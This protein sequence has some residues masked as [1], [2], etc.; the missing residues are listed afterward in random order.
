MS[1]F[2]ELKESFKRQLLR[3]VQE[4]LFGHFE[5]TISAYQRQIDHKRRL[6]DLVSDPDKLRTSVFPA[7]VLSVDKEQLDRSSVLDQEAA[8]GDNDGSGF[9]QAVGGPTDPEHRPPVSA[10]LSSHMST[11]SKACEQRRHTPSASSQQQSRRFTC[12]VCGL[13]LRLRRQLKLHMKRHMGEKPHSCSLCNQTFP[14][15]EQLN[16]H[17]CPGSSEKQET[18]RAS[19]RSL[20]GDAFRVRSSLRSHRTRQCIKKRLSCSEPGRQQLLKSQLKQQRKRHRDRL[21]KSL[22]RF[23]DRRRVPLTCPTC[24]DVF[25]N[26]SSLTLHKKLH[27][28]ELACAACGVQ[29]HS[30]SQL[31]AHMMKCGEKP[32]RCPTCGRR[33]SRRGHLKRH[34]AVHTKVRPHSCGQCGQRFFRRGSLRT[35][36]CPCRSLHSRAGS[37]PVR[38]PG[39]GR[40]TAHGAYAENDVTAERQQSPEQVS[41]LDLKSSVGSGLSCSFCGKGFSCAGSLT[42]HVSVHTGQT[43]LSCIICAKKFAS[44][45]ELIGHDCASESTEPPQNHGAGSLSCSVCSIVFSDTDALV[46]HMRSH[47]RLTRFTCPVCAKDFAWRRHLTK[48]M[49]VHQTHRGRRAPSH[50]QHVGGPSAADG[51]GVSAASRCLHQLDFSDC[52]TDDSDFWTNPSPEANSVDADDVS[53]KQAEDKEQ[54]EQTELKQEQTELT[55]EQTELT[56][57]QTELKQE[58]P[59][60]KEEQEEAQISTSSFGLVHMKTEEEEKPVSSELPHRDSALCAETEDSEDRDPLSGSNLVTESLQQE[61]DGSVDSDFWKDDRDGKHRSS[62][63]RHGAQ[64]RGVDA[65]ARPRPEHKPLVC[66]VCGQTCLYESHLKIHMRTHTGEKPFSCPICGKKYAHKASMQAHVSVHTIDHRYHCSA[67]G[68]SFAWFTELK[69][70]QCAGQPPPSGAT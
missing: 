3:S 39:P 41:S 40:S 60:V 33:F 16:G 57:E 22:K 26:R 36:K 27:Q 17:S 45:S 30:N 21:F 62:S 53:R 2:R 9:S 65:E 44:E 13:Q 34:M 19:R 6:L 28:N 11:H 42:R 20:R 4:R 29:L 8:G 50:R 66:A 63:K 56:Q 38:Y 31:D 47:A 70:H 14:G 18:Q 54:Q 43:L 67:C 64:H 1:R 59:W 5:E 7:D 35:H 10:G 48:H 58:Q 52:D 23:Q 68:R 25:T 12:G 55:Q 15:Q 61:S 46:E 51:G 32:H 37:E 24:G 69:Y 49:E